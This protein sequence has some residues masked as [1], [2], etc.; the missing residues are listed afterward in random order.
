MAHHGQKG[1]M[2][3]KGRKQAEKWWN[4][5]QLMS[6]GDRRVLGAAAAAGSPSES[7]GEYQSK[8]K[9]WSNAR[10]PRL[11]AKKREGLHN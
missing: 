9:Q 1:Q 8:V 7:A 6:Q 2:K 5:G 10:G 4:N 3:C 11:L